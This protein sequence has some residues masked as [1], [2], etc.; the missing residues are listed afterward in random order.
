MRWA[1]AR[2]RRT[3]QQLRCVDPV[4]KALRLERP[5][6]ELGGLFVREAPHRRLARDARVALDAG[7]LGAREPVVVVVRE[8][9]GAEVPREPHL[10]GL[11]D[12]PVQ[13]HP[14]RRGHLLV[15]RLADG[16]VDEP[17]GA[18]ARPR[19]DDARLRR[20]VERHEEP[21]P[22][23]PQGALQDRQLELLPDDA[24]HLERL[25]GLHGQTGEPGAQH[26]PG[27]AQARGC[28]RS[29]ER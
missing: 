18:G 25:A 26:V 5:A 27:D 8:I 1:A 24:R 19:R 3:S 2:A 17:V 11:G 12:A 29:R 13:V 6:E 15:E 4:L 28:R 16:L 20:L 10:D 7:R 9:V 21:L 22:R 14:E 23:D